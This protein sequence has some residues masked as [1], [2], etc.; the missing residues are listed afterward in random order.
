MTG[1]DIL[2]A[3]AACQ[4]PKED[5]VWL[6]PKGAPTLPGQGLLMCAHCGAHKRGR[7]WMVPYLV[8]CAC[9]VVLNPSR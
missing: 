7:N 1:K 9:K 3:F 5:R 8:A 6:D 2:K 4:H